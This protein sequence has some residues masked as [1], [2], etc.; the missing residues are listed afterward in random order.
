ME[1]QL[2]GGEG[3]QGAAH[4]GR[5]HFTLLV[6]GGTQAEVRNLCS[7]VLR[8]QGTSQETNTNLLL[9]MRAYTDSLSKSHVGQS[10]PH[11]GPMTL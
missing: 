3:L 4:A 2:A 10:V 5:T 1:G 11:A 6:W 9:Y 8:G 7:V